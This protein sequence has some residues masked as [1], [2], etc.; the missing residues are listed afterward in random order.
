LVGV[1]LLVREIARDTVVDRGGSLM[2]SLRFGLPNWAANLLQQINYRLDV[3]ILG[4]FATAQDVGVYSVA[5]T[6]TGIAWV[7][8]QALQT[9][10]FPRVA[11]LDEAT[12][13]GELAVEE[14]NAAVAK[15][16]RHAVLLTLPSAL[17]ISILL[18]VGVPLIYGHKFHQTTWLGF[19]LLP[20]VLLLGIGKV[21][22]STISGRG[23]PRYA[24]Y[25][26]AISTPLTVGLYAWLIPLFHAWGAA[27]AS[28]VSYGLSAFL[29][30]FFFR[31]VTTIGI[32]D[33]FVPRA[34]DVSDY[35]GLARLARAWRPRRPLGPSGR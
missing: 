9:V 18:L 20:G 30:V 14:S 29:A 22:S 19:V 2:R 10:L 12:A 26:A 32:R 11:G 3:L 7:L 17:A 27:A 35:G 1:F 13:A 15:A 25:I 4:A 31:R 21:L 23:Y 33:A 34:S 8:P 16:V 6:V 5:L 24:T 28:S